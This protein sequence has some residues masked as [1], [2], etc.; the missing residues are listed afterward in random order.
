MATGSRRLSESGGAKSMLIVL[1]A[2]L[3][4]CASVHLGA[5]IPCDELQKPS[6]AQ[7]PNTNESQL[8]VITWNLH[9]IP[10]AGDI[11]ARLRRVASEL[12]SRGSDLLLLQEVWFD[13]DAQELEAAL[14]DTYK[15][16][17]DD[18]KVSSG[19]MNFIGGFR[20]GGLLALVKKDSAWTFNA[21]ASVF[22]E[23]KLAAPKRRFLNEGD[24]ISGKGI[25]R[26]VLS[27]KNSPRKVQIFN[28]HLQS[29]YGVGRRYVQI[30]KAQ[31][32]ELTKL[33][34]SENDANQELV[35]QLVF[36]DFNT[37]PT[38]R[39][40]YKKLTEKWSD[41][42]SHKREEC[43]CGT[44]LDVDEDLQDGTPIAIEAEWIDFAL[45]RRDT[46]VKVVDAWRIPSSDSKIDCPFS[47]HYGLELLLRIGD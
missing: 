1:I 9:G 5:E 6:T 11:R 44:S 29:Q 27:I 3:S 20:N 31:I 40:L 39:A 32:D 4:G 43:N 14:S 47:D 12:S 18:P 16:V 36:G 8:R 26:F 30:R 10:L 46:N 35:T 22:S 23:Y 13:G 33:A 17:P 25:Q 42:T 45:A 2:L 15:R 38:E 37:F 21:E 24:G 7:P 34:D 28:T 41:L 19:I